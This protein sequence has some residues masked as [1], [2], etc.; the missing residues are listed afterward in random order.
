MQARL[1]RPSPALVVAIV[2]LIAALTGTAWAALGKNSV[3]SKQLKKN[4]VVSTKI[5]NNAVTTP[6]IRN[7]AV[8]TEKLQDGGVTTSKIKDG[9]V[10]G[11][12]VN[13]ASLG[14]VPSASTATTASNLA[15][16]QSFFI[17]LNGGQSQ[18]I[19]SNGSV[20]LVA[21][22]EANVG[23]K[24]IVTILGQTTLSGAILAGID[25]LSGPGGSGEFLEP[26][27]LAEKRRF[28]SLSDTTG[29][30]NV[31][32]SIDQGYVLG[33]DGKMITAN[34]EG[35]A[36]GLNYGGSTCLTAGIVN[37]IG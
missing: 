9:A 2:A 10:T 15:G 13:L 21:T 25:N 35:I 29:D 17:R 5:K 19:A 33:P 24:D 6:K 26:N 31:S 18:T 3:G 22:C 12:K 1:R 36:L 37:S 32:A 4:A 20:S 30:I 11:P 16:Q 7:G 28:V 27:T 8:V 34:S 23:G 14:T